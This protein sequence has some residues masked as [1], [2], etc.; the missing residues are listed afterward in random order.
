MGILNKIAIKRMEYRIKRVKKDITNPNGRFSRMIESSV[1]NTADYFADKVSSLNDFKS[2]SGT[3]I[4]GLRR[5][6][7]FDYTT[8][9]AEL[10]DEEKMDTYVNSRNPMKHS[11]H[12][13]RTY[14]SYW[15]LLWKGWGNQGDRTKLGYELALR[16]MDPASGRTFVTSPFDKNRDSYTIINTFRHPGKKGRDWFEIFETD[17]NKFFKNDLSVKLDTYFKKM[18]L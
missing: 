8:G 18:G 13:S 12:N 14:P 15:E 17:Y 3:V 5:S 6:Y 16:V 2:K 1:A 9:T 10:V 11:R 7:S 4:E